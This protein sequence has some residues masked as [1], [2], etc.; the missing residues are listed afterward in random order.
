[1]YFIYYDIHVPTDLIQNKATTKRGVY[2]H[3]TII[4]DFGV[5]IGSF[6]TL[7]LALRCNTPSLYANETEH[8]Y[9][10][11]FSHFDYL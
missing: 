4:Y 7:L 9:K 2:K 3:H 1:M 6:F 11:E 10:I 8:D 5:A